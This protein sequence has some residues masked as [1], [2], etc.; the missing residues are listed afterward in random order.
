MAKSRKKK[1]TFL[2]GVVIYFSAFFCLFFFFVLLSCIIFP[3]N[4]DL[5]DWYIGFISFFSLIAPFF[6]TLHVKKKMQNRPNNNAF[7]SDRIVVEIPS[8]YVP[9]AKPVKATPENAQFSNSNSAS[10]QA[11]YSVHQ[12]LYF[13]NGQLNKIE[14][15]QENWYDPM[16]IVYGGESYNMET[17]ES[18]NSMKI[19]KFAFNDGFTGYGTT[20]SLDYVVR[21]KAAHLRNKGKVAESDA[22]YRKST[23]LMQASGIP[24]DMTPYLYLAKELLREGRFEESEKE[25][26]RIYAIFHTTRKSVNSNPKIR[27]YITQEDR[28]YYR[29]KYLLPNVAPKSISGYTRMKKENTPNFQ[30][31]YAAA[32]SAGISINAYSVKK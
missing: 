8:A 25:E 28:E 23:D 13:K 15:N 11:S 14:G 17:V 3:F 19:P 27:P 31:I 24:Y 22:C 4:E 7:A 10:K 6:V 29:I 12:T 20:G 21:M 30:K 9:Y 5:P 2:L 32:T 18:I 26:D 1:Y 16:Y